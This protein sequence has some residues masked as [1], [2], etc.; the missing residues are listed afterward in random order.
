MRRVF[1]RDSLLVNTVRKERKLNEEVEANG[2][3]HRA[4][5]PTSACEREEGD[6]DC[7]PVA[8]LIGHPFPQSIVRLLLHL[9]ACCSVCF[10]CDVDCS[11]TAVLQSATWVQGRS[12]NRPKGHRGRLWEIR[13]QSQDCSLAPTTQCHC[14]GSH[15]EPPEP[16]QVPPRMATR[17]VI[18]IVGG[19]VVAPAETQMLGKSPLPG[20][21]PGF[22]F[23]CAPAP[24]RGL[25]RGSS[26]TAE[27]RPQRGLAVT[28]SALGALC[29]TLDRPRL[30]L[31]SPS[32]SSTIVFEMSGSETAT[33]HYILISQPIRQ[34][35]IFIC[36]ALY[37]PVEPSCLLSSLSSIY[38]SMLRFSCRAQTCAGNTQHTSQHN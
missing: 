34:I 25:Q 15:L 23:L 10:D 35:Y 8:F 11:G 19:F 33:L 17:S 37:L 24:I 9:L 7:G 6:C 5:S 20:P 32:C 16:R 14:P 30:L 29:L 31:V 36:G 38:Q 4:V 28:S 1:R 12:V 2:R 26:G 3:R 21:A 13:E 27:S 18:F 22:L